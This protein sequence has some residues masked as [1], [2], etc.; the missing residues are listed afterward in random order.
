MKFKEFTTKIEFPIFN[1][2]FWVCLTDDIEASRKAQ[3]HWLGAVEGYFNPL[4][5]GLHSYNEMEG[6]TAAIFIKPYSSLGVIAHEVFHALWRMF[7][8]VGAN[9]E[10]ETFA[11]HLSYSLDLITKFVVKNDKKFKNVKK[12]KL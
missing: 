6:G 12:P 8:Y 2:H 4:I 5:D 3:S 7:E 9:I 10:N 11:Y 1:Y